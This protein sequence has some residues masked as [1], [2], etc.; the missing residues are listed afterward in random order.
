[1]PRLFQSTLYASCICFFHQRQGN[2]LYFVLSSYITNN[3]MIMKNPANLIVILV[4]FIV[5]SSCIK[6]PAAMFSYDPST[7][8]EAGEE[9]K[10]N[11]ETLD[12]NDY[13]WD[14]GNG[15]TSEEEMP[16]TRFKP[17]G[18]YTVTLTASNTFKSSTYSENILIHPPTILDFWVYDTDGLPISTGYAELYPTYGDAMNGTNM[19][20]SKTSNQDG[21]ASF[22]NLEAQSYYLLFTKYTP[23]GAWAAGGNIGPLVQN[24]VNE[25]WAIAEFYTDVYKSMKSTENIM[26]KK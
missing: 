26:K 23:T 5:S 18:N 9:I 1:M 3:N 24:Q 8:P 13:Y 17:P 19:I 15:L 16:S 21:R 12:A 20:S 10:F 11:N 25:Y 14:F 22:N 2:F 4:V 7:N 6:E